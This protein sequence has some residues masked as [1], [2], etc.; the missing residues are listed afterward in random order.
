MRSQRRASRLRAM[1]PAVRL[2][3]AACA[4]V[5]ASLAV[6]PVAGAAAKT[7]AA[8]HH[9][10]AAELR[11]KATRPSA[12][13]AKPG[14]R[15]TVK[16]TLR[17]A[18]RG[19]AAAT[20]T[21]V[22]L[23][24]SR[25]FADGDLV[26]ATLR[27]R[28]LAA[29]RSAKAVTAKLTIPLDGRATG[30]RTLLACADATSKVRE[31]NEKDNCAVA[32]T[33]T[34]PAV[35]ASGLIA[36]DLAAKRI[37]AEQAWALDLLTKVGSPNALP[38]RYRGATAER[39]AEATALVAQ[40]S[41]RF[42]ALAPK[43][44]QLLAPLFLP[45]TA[46]ARPKGKATNKA[47]AAVVRR[48]RHDPL[49]PNSCIG[50]AANMV[51]DFD[52]WESITAPSSRVVFWF[53]AG[54]KGRRATARTFA[55]AM[56][57]T[58]W[59]KLTK[60]INR[61]PRPDDRL[62]C[63][64]GN[65]AGLDVYLEPSVG[66]GVT[67]NYNC[68]KGQAN[69]S[70][71]RVGDG[72]VETLAHE[73]F[74]ALQFAVPD[75]T[76]CAR[77]EWIDEGTASFA[78]EYA[79]PGTMQNTSADWL[80]KFAPALPTRSYEAWTFWHDVAV[81]AGPE[82]IAKVFDY[83]TRTDDRMEAVDLGIG[84]LRKRWPEFAR[85]AYNQ[86]PVHSFATW[87]VRTDKHP[88]MQHPTVVSLGGAQTKEVPY[89]GG[90]HPAPLTRDYTEFAFADDVHKVTLVGAP[91]DPDH[92]IHAL[93]HFKDGAWAE[94]DFDKDI[95]Y[96]RDRPSEAVQEI[97]LI[98]TNASPSTAVS[99]NPH[100]VLQDSCDVPHFKV[101]AA[102]MKNFTTGSTSDKWGQSCDAFDVSGTEDYS[103]TLDHAVTDPAFL[104]K[105]KYG[106]GFESR[107]DFDI[108]ADGMAELHGCTEGSPETKCDTTRS[109]RKADGKEQIGFSI[110]VAPGA[111]TA[112][113]R[114]TI[115][116]ASI[117]YFDADDSVCNV[118]EFYNH[119]DFSDQDQ[120]VPLE[121]L[122]HGSHTF[123]NAGSRSWHTD[124]KTGNAAELALNWSYEITVQVVD[125]D[126]HPIP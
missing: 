107:L 53:P 6:L 98:A 73:F 90:A 74:H 45:P 5:S 76:S 123:T 83:L 33:I 65:S 51:D 124:G 95:T 64:H 96:C 56:D 97:V 47:K 24:T 27:Q 21:R 7:P 80:E 121:Q 54:D 41:Q 23:G 38:E 92:K 109:I 84:R 29:G 1:P 20:A 114:W 93:V 42:A 115:Q 119:V 8:Q 79:Y 108:P 101:I 40:A 18:G 102:K 17:N 71:V 25:T 99:A 69:S 31:R 11:V 43:T 60:L 52:G 36:A 22:S 66:Q 28:A 89:A 85:D 75:R 57:T 117:G 58:I 32:A 116:E 88:D 111:E 37:D 82:S 12:V 39:S 59:P 13:A 10:P 100:L 2:P 105:P 86:E 110:D 30:R 113:L 104:L 16:V 4:I 72:R 91:T 126:G 94:Q 70:F 55:A 15:I 118:Y 46:K 62:D 68:V 34:F 87:T 78:S 120:T 26:L 44:Q 35:S 61:E 122:Q 106:G 19:R 63:A 14:D 3:L 81:R 50:D 48:P 103:G 77:P 49:N 67:V 125:A 9:A 112:R